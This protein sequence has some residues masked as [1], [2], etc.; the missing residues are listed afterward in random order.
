MNDFDPTPED[1]P[2]LK[3]KPIPVQDGYLWAHP[4]PSFLWPERYG[5][6][7][8]PEELTA[9]RAVIACVGGWHRN[10]PAA[11]AE[12][13]RRNDCIDVAATA[14]FFI[15]QPIRHRPDIADWLGEKAR[16]DDLI[17]Q[18]VPQLMGSDWDDGGT[19]DQHLL[20]ELDMISF[21]EIVAADDE[22][23]ARKFVGRTGL[24]DETPVFGSASAGT[25]VLAR[26]WPVETYE[27]MR[28]TFG[29]T[30]R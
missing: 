21:A 8:T 11:V 24:L 28:E 29:G 1:R 9:A 13:L 22:D 3:G 2:S 4:L 18:Q 25:R 15:A 6:L 16:Q 23:G 26:L 12:V 17:R 7:Q 14:T 30:Q 10:D 27:R 5:G 20:A 19:A